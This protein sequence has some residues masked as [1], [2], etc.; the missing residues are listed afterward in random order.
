MNKNRA[1]KN[2]KI[3]KGLLV[4]LTFIIV[5]IIPMSEIFAF[6]PDYPDFIWTYNN[7]TRKI[8]A[9]AQ[10]AVYLTGYSLSSEAKRRDIYRLIEETELN[11]IVFNAKE[12]SG[13]I[14]YNSSV[15][16]FN[17]TGSVKSYYDIDQ[18][19]REM[20]E[21]NIYS[22]KTESYHIRGRTWQCRIRTQ[23]NLFTWM[24]VTGLIY[25]AGRYGTIS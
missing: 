9:G 18:V 16:F 10:K 15:D 20:D 24:E 13:E 21:R 22:S 1:T 2:L 8:T 14:L 25:T 5:S 3:F 12:D 6:D 11:S 7:R 19:L 23:V 17:K 4:L